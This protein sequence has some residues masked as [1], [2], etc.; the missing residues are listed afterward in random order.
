M[1][2]DEYPV[3]VSSATAE[4]RLN[5]DFGQLVIGSTMSTSHVRTGTSP[6]GSPERTHLSPETSAVGVGGEEP[7]SGVTAERDRKETKERGK[8]NEIDGLREGEKGA[9]VNEER[10]KETEEGQIGRELGD[11]GATGQ[12]EGETAGG[13]RD[14]TGG[15]EEKE[16]GEGEKTG[17]EGERGKQKGG[18]HA[19]AKSDRKGGSGTSPPPS[20][21]E[22]PECPICC[23]PLVH[24]VKTPC[25]HIF[26]FLCIK[27]V[28]ARDNR[29]CMCRKQVP[30]DFLDRPSLL[31]TPQ[32]ETAEGGAGEGQYH[33]Y[34][35]ARSA[36]WWMFE[37]RTSADIEEAYQRK[38]ERTRVYIAGFQYIIDFKQ[39]IQYRE[40]YPDRTRRIKREKAMNA[41]DV[42]G[43]AGIK[44][45]TSTS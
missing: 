23:S 4:E 22:A 29:C 32:L 36:G 2:D 7:I 38:L 26:C 30:P 16:S 25:G 31:A 18:K 41:K 14:K 5:T 10:G 45:T 1:A 40:E 20:K 42:K 35:S 15:E 8:E 11:E 3:E 21:D 17:G 33:W 43:V 34:Y 13:E 37:E 19:T 12:R 28:L 24:P 27:G 44:A 9:K 39:M 6:F